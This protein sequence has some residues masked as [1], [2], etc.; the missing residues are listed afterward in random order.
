M[1]VI[2]PLWSGSPAALHAFV[3]QTGWTRTIWNFF[4]PPWQVARMLPI[5]GALAAAWVYE[6]Q[7]MYIAVA[8]GCMVVAL[9]M[10]RFYIYRINDILFTK[11]GT[12]MA[13]ADVT[14]LI[15]RWILAD[16]VRFT[17]GLVALFALMQAFRSPITRE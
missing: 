3:T 10:T 1:L 17:I 12:G 11:A 8:A 7:R 9:I 13:T 2:V 15:H 16:R 6:C 4:G 5:F 14:S